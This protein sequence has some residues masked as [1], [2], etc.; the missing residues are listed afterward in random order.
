MI[1]YLPPECVSSDSE[2]DTVS[3]SSGDLDLAFALHVG[4]R[5]QIS[6]TT[7]IGFGA[8]EASAIDNAVGSL[9]NGFRSERQESYF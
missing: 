7:A 1:K 4:D 6:W 5:D 3:A 9:E 2:L 8:D